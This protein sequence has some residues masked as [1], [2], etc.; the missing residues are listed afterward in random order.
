MGKISIIVTQGTI[1]NGY[2]KIGN[3]Q[4]FPR[5]AFGASNA[6]QGV[7][8]LLRLHLSGINQTIVTDITEDKLIFRNR[9][10]FTPFY[11]HYQL[12]PGDE[13]TI[14]KVSESDYRIYPSRQSRFPPR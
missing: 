5:D 4:F 11:N 6:K 12:H 10:W 1:N 2:L 8:R 14:E 13:I 9:K 7:G 3:R